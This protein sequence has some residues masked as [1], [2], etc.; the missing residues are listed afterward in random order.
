[1]PLFSSLQDF[2][3]LYEMP[4]ARVFHEIDRR[5]IMVDATRLE[6]FVKMLDARLEIC[7]QKIESAV[8]L[9]VVAKQPKGEKTPKGT[10]NLSSPTQLV[11]MLTG[12]G[13]K[14]KTSWQTGNPTSNEE[15]LN[16]AYAKT[17]NQVLRNILEARE[18]NKLK[19]TYAEAALLDGI[20]YSSWNVSGTVS[21]RRSSGSTIFQSSSGKKIGTNTQNLPKQSELGRS[22]RECL[23]ARPG[24]IFVSCDQAQ[25]EDWIV[26][27]L[28]ADNGGGTRGLDELTQRVDRH[29]KLASKIFKKPESECSKGTMLRFM[30]KKT[31]HAGNYGE[32]PGM[33]ATSLIKE[34]PDAVE[35]MSRDGKLIPYCEVLLNAFHENEPEI[36]NTFQNYVESE[37][38]RCRTLK[39][40]IGRERYFFGLR[41]G[42]DNSKLFKEAFSYIPQSTVGDNTG[43]SIL[44]CE[45]NSPG[46]VLLD[47][48][49]SITLESEDSEEEIRNSIELLKKAFDRKLIFPNGTE[50]KIPVEV[51]IGYDLMNE[52][53]CPESSMTG[54]QPMLRTLRLQAKRL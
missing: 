10:L 44:F 35:Q 33:M 21:G 42:A 1:V 22:F 17:G 38:R 41:P 12:L 28:I 27:G 6:A 37:L 36:R 29:R 48:H 39:T 11:S 51:E 3:N 45:K 5:G 15:A 24:R 14:L 46:L 20:L 30:G 50:V 49:D 9:K 25:A 26:S 19:G 18:Y 4:L 2:C 31:R 43:L 8:K 13:I 47:G 7:C 32:G 54:L 16:E 23:V 52:V 34:V 40:P 53:E